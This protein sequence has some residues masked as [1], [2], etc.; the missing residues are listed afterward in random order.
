MRTV[1]L[2]DGSKWSGEEIAGVAV[3]TGDPRHVDA[4]TRLVRFR[5]PRG[6]EMT[7]EVLGTLAAAPDDTLRSL[8]EAERKRI[9]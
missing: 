9:G 8:I 4:S 5:G 2:D 7:V 3:L 6:Q 1:V